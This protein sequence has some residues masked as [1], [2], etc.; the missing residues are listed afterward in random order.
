MEPIEIRTV[1]VT[2][3]S[4]GFAISI[5]AV[6][7]LSLVI[8]LSLALVVGGIVFFLRSSGAKNRL[9][10]ST[11]LLVGGLVIA[12]TLGLGTAE[13]IGNSAASGLLVAEVALGLLVAEVALLAAAFWVW[14]LVE[15]AVKEA[16][17][18]N[19]KLTWVVII[20]FTN[21]VGA[22]LYFFVRR[23]QRLAEVGR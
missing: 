2:M 14:M 19:N 21:I 4:G 7:I 16:D 15:C 6:V 1:V 10:V 22:A 18:G 8:L 9:A 17:Y 3:S 23:P 5:A 13:I 20:V 12:L 11:V